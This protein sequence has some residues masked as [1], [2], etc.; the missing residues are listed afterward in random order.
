MFDSASR[1]NGSYFWHMRTPKLSGLR[2]T[3]RSGPTPTSR[4]WSPIGEEKL[5]E[6]EI[7]TLYFLTTKR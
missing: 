5:R 1:Q 2:R 3:E 4:T 6:E 7:R